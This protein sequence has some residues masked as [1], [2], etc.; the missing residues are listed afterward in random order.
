M[1]LTKI[2]SVLDSHWVSSSFRSVSIVWNGY[3]ALVTH[4]KE[5]AID[6]WRTANERKK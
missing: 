1:Q 4:F 3:A 2:G 5:A 6:T